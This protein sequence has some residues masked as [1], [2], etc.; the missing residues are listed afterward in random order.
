M[1]ELIVAAI[2]LCAAL[3]VAKRYLPDSLQ[4]KLRTHLSNLA[5]RVGWSALG[6]KLA[7]P[8][9]SGATCGTGCGKCGSSDATG[10]AP[11]ASITPDA[12]KRTIRR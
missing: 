6:A 8:V 4:R 11:Q 12:L 2:V 5:E 3:V 1:Q 7:P 9:R 10:S